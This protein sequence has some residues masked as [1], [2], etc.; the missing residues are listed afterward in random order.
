MRGTVPSLVAQWWRIY[1]TCKTRGGQSLGP[2]DPLEEGMATHARILAWWV[3]STEKPGGLQS[4]GLQRVAHDWSNWARTSGVSQQMECEEW[5][6][7]K[8]KNGEKW[9]QILHVTFSHLFSWS[10]FY[11]CM[12]QTPSRPTINSWILR[13]VAAPYIQD[14]VWN[15]IS[16]KVKG[17]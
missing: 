16:A 13:S 8:V 10:L 12:G 2:E 15:F 9:P 17:C 14:S 3:S 5:N 6:C 1:L 7:T 4:I 11:E